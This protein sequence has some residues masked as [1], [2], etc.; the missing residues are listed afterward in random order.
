MNR[1][2]GVVYPTMGSNTIQGYG[3][4]RRHMNYKKKMN[5]TGT[6]A[7]LTSEVPQEMRKMCPLLLGNSGLIPTSFE[8]TLESS[9]VVPANSFKS[10]LERWF[11][12]GHCKQS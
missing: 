9:C 10:N 6:N 1:S 11:P 5:T 2:R 12:R 7:G 3:K 4:E 8:L